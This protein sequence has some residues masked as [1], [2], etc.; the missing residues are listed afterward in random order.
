[1]KK[2]LSLFMNKPLF[3]FNML[4]SNYNI[5]NF[6]IKN[7]SEKQDTKPKAATTLKP[8]EV[9]KYIPYETLTKEEK[10]LFRQEQLK[11]LYKEYGHN[12]NLVYR[13]QY[14]PIWE[15]Y[16]KKRRQGYLNTNLVYLSKDFEI[17]VLR[18]RK[19]T[20]NIN[21]LFRQGLMP[22]RIFGREDFA[23]LNLVVKRGDIEKTTR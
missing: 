18:H 10:R 20:D 14:M 1:M 7:F 13:H 8:G 6:N 16:S 21:D 17:Q 9:N 23:E 5:F 3:K 15:E 12:K 4:K 2:Q 19:A 22:I 11:E